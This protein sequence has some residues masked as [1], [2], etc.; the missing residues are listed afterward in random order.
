MQGA[1]LIRLKTKLNEIIKCY[2][3]FNF[4]FIYSK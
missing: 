2:I 4:I 1:I 3:K